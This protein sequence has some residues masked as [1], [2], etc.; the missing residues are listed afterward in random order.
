MATL[1]SILVRIPEPKTGQARQGRAGLACT[2]TRTHTFGQT[3]QS[4]SPGQVDWVSRVGTS[5]PGALAF[6]LAT[7]G[8]G[9]PTGPWAD[10]QGLPGVP[11]LCCSAPVLAPAQCAALQGQAAL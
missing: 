5:G 4:D 1:Q 9:G 2:H 7:A 10:F 11:A 8:R 6:S 3:P